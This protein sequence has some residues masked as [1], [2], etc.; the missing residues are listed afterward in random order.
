MYRR[1]K[2]VRV[3]GDEPDGEGDVRVLGVELGE[4]SEVRRAMLEKIADL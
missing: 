4:S 3:E 2:D 1:A